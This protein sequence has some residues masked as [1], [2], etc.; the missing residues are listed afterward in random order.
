MEQKQLLVVKNCS[1]EG[2]GL[3]ADV[4]RQYNVALDVRDLDRGAKLPDTLNCYCGVVILG[5]PDSAND[6]TPKMRAELQFAHQ[7]LKSPVPALGICLGLQV[8]VQAA[9][10]AVA[11]CQEPERGFRDGAGNLF[12]MQRC[13]D[14]DTDKLA[15]CMHEPRWEVFQLHGEQV[16]LTAD[17][18][19]LAAGEQCRNQFVRVTPR[20]WGLQCHIELTPE[21]FIAL[22]Q[23]DPDL[24]RMDQDALRAE[25]DELWPV[26]RRRGQ[27]LLSAFLA[28]CTQ[29]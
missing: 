14:P 5:G 20:C 17:M 22:L 9:G 24:R 12:V 15:R 23:H 25:F 19:L 4:A 18:L 27:A 10:G 16:E 13:V 1:H 6:A 3:V 29:Q 11:H 8:L 28:L 7:L 2:P 26:Y 21:L